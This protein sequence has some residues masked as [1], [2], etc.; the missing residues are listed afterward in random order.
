MQHRAP[1]GHDATGCSFGL[2]SPRR[3]KLILQLGLAM[4]LCAVA[5]TRAN[6][7]EQPPSGFRVVVHAANSASSAPSDFVMSA[8]LKKTSRWPEGELIQPVDLRFGSPVREAFSQSIL[9]RSAAAVRNYWQQRI[10][11]G[12]GVPPPEVSSDADVIRYVQ[13]H[14]GG[15]G[16]VSTQADAANVKV[17]VIR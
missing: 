11:T 10:F 13:E 6:G 1:P 17:L 14:P 15:V 8:F 16:Y 9:Q 7:A 3:L 5:L 12:R 2:P 4:A